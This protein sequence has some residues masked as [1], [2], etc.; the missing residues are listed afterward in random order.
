MRTLGK[1]VTSAENFR[2]TVFRYIKFTGNST[3]GEIDV[4]RYGQP[5]AIITKI[6][7]PDHPDYNYDLYHPAGNALD[8]VRLGSGYAVLAPTKW[9]SMPTST[10]SEFACATPGLQTVCKLTNAIEATGKAAPPG[11][12]KSAGRL[13]DG[14]IESRTQITLKA[15]LDATVISIPA[16]ITSRIEPAMMGALIPVRILANTDGTLRKIELNG[17]VPGSTGKM[18]IQIG[19]EAKGPSGP[20]DFPPLP[21]PAEVTALSDKAAADEFRTRM[22]Q[23]H[24]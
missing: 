3:T 15:F 2:G 11:L 8:Y 21:R 22:L 23:I 19:Y 17:E 12:T 1:Y 14:A 5:P 16:D 13:D 9:V 10:S 18:Q 4:S 20:E 6:R 7:S 24:A